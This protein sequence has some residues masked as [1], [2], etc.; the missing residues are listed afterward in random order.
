MSDNDN[1]SFE[2]IDP[3]PYLYGPSNKTDSWYTGTFFET[4]IYQK[5]REKC[6]KEPDKI[7]T[8]FIDQGVMPDN[9][10]V[11]RMETLNAIMQA[12]LVPKNLK[13]AISANK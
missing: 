8:V 11:D 13:F 1:F 12:G 10:F 6:E 7:Q 5:L 2:E 3:K 9:E 4:P